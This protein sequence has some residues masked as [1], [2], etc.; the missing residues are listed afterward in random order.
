LFH[1]PPLAA[2]AIGAVY[3]LALWPLAGD[4]SGARLSVKVVE[5]AD[6][7]THPIAEGDDDMANL[8]DDSFPTTRI[9]VFSGPPAAKFFV[10][11]LRGIAVD[12]HPSGVD[13]TIALPDGIAL[14]RVEPSDHAQVT[15]FVEALG[16]GLPP[17]LVMTA[18]RPLG[19]IATLLVLGTPLLLFAAAFRLTENFVFPRMPVVAV[20]ALVGAC[21]FAGVPLAIAYTRRR[22]LLGIDG[23]RVENLLFKEK[24][25]LAA[26]FRELKPQ[27][28]G[29][30]PERL[31]FLGRRRDG[32]VKRSSSLEFRSVAERDRFLA[33][34]HD[35]GRFQHADVGNVLAR[36]CEDGPWMQRLARLAMGA[37]GYRDGALDGPTLVAALTAH[38]QN[39]R[40]AAARILAPQE[41]MRVRVREAAQASTDAE[42]RS[43]MEALATAPN[44]EAREAALHRWV[45][46][47]PRK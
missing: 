38:D 5:R 40:V 39:V 20:A 34:L 16:P 41:A 35:L 19:P 6:P 26:M 42:V 17:A 30:V 36:D 31:H 8:E 1:V 15:P 11:D 43:C 24:R 45:A 23:L 25:E 12:R 22:V 33:R 7:R 47:T 32:R 37:G 29:I 2:A 18:A 46:A 44:E 27:Q 4:V 9:L 14:F 10:D 13:L 21:L 28:D 3:F